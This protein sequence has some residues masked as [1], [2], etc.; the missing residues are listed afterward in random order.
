MRLFLIGLPGCGKST[1]GRA[2]ALRLDVGFIDL[3]LYIEGRWHRSV[4]DMFATVG[5]EEFRRRENAMLR[6]AG[7]M[8]N[9]I[10][11]CGGGTPLGEGNMDYMLSRGDVV[12]LTASEDVLVR[13]ILLA[14]TRRPAF[15][16]LDEAKVRAK[17][18]GLVDAR[19]RIYSRAPLRFCGDS[20]E[21]R[22]LIDASVER[23]ISEINIQ[24]KDTPSNQIL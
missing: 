10:V 12:W 8:D 16:G 17:I 11:A 5:E 22:R 13:R 6:E 7:E 2:L 20:L 4:A 9:V 19:S 3:D 24:P 15:A 23:F 14:G 21:N 1:L 18:R